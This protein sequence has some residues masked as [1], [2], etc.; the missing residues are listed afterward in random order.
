MARTQHS[1]ETKAAVLAALLTG[2]SAAEVAKAYSLPEGT[3]KSW[4][5]RSNST[6]GVASVAP[7][8]K[9]HVGELLVTYLEASLKTLHEQVVFFR[10]PAWLAKQNAADA[11]VLHGVLTDKAVRLLEALNASSGPS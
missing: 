9:G 1:A 8:K 11:A 6:Q 4:R 10:D 5:E 3:V 2:Q 7:D